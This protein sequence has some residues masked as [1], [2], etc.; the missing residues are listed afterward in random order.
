MLWFVL[1][2]YSKTTT[3]WSRQPNHA[4]LPPASLSSPILISLENLAKQDVLSCLLQTQSSR[5]DTCATVSIRVWGWWGCE[6][7]AVW[8]FPH[9]PTCTAGSS[10]RAKLKHLI[11]QNYNSSQSVK[12][13]QTN[14][15]E[16]P[17]PLI[18][19]QCMQTKDQWQ[20]GCWSII[21]RLSHITSFRETARL[22]MSYEASVMEQAMETARKR[23][24]ESY[25]EDG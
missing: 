6:R 21:L 9:W 18:P 15:V 14:L 20:S 16:L 7:G 4:T 8:R 5:W 10:A 19:T 22:K 24:L 2:Q 23:V 1:H 25:D 12:R 11:T 3:P 13:V 17:A